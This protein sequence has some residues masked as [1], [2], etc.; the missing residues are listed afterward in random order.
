MKEVRGTLDNIDVPLS[1]L[2]I[3]IE[4]LLIALLAFMPLA[5]GARHA[6]SE[7]VVIILSCAITICFFLKLVLYPDQ[8]II[9][10]WAYIPILA[11]LL[12]AVL[13]LASLPV[14]LVKII[15]PNTAALKTEL[16]HDLSGAAGIKSMSLSFYRSA[17]KH[18]LRLVASIAA[19]FVVILNVF[20]KPSQIKRLLMA[21]SII[22]GIV[23][24]IAMAQNLFGNG[25][26]YW[27]VSTPSGQAS[28]GPFI[29]H[30]HFGQFMNLSIGAAIGLL[31]VKLHEVFG[32][33]KRGSFVFKY[34]FS[35]KAKFIWFLAAFI[36]I[37]AATLVI[38]LTRGGILSMLAAAVFTTL[39]INSRQALKARGWILA[40][41]ALG[42]FVCVLY[43]GFD[44][45]YD[46]FARLRNFGD[47]QCRLQILKDL[48]V[49]FKRFPILGMGLGT[50]AMVYPM[51]SHLS[52]SRI[53]THA[54]NEY[55]Q[56]ME[57]T[58]LLGLIIL[59]VFAVIIWSNYTKSVR[60][61]NTPTRPAVYGL[62]FGILAI[63]LHSITDYG[64]HI[65]ANAFLSAIFCALIIVLAQQG[66]NNK[67]YN[68]RIPI[69]NFIMLLGVSGICIWALVGANNARVAEAH[70]QRALDVE[71]SFIDKNWQGTEQEYA[72]LISHTAAASNAEQDNIK[73]RYWLNVY[74]WRS[75]SQEK[76]PETGNTVIHEEKIPVIYD[77][78]DQLHKACVLCPTYG[79]TYSV[80]GQLENFVLSN[81]AGAEQI[82]KG[83]RLAP[84]DPVACFVAGK[85][86][87]AEGKTDD[88]IEKFE[89]AVALDTRLF[90]KVV[91]IY[92]NQ[93]SR[94]HPAI[95]I[96]GN[97][98]GWL[99][100]VISLLE[101]MQ[102]YDLAQQTRTKV[103]NLLE[104]QC[105]QPKAIAST[106]A[107][108]ADIYR[109]QQN[110]EAAVEYYHSALA[111]DYGQVKWRFTLAKLLVEMERIPEAMREAERCLR[112][113]P[114]FKKARDLIADL[115]VHPMML[116]QEN[117]VP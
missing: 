8:N 89:K 105:R 73:Y 80:V 75:I 23:A 13:Q 90:V 29:N 97:N 17:T 59:I 50:H 67:V 54:E 25:K 94:P 62:G 27:F 93:I 14:S 91:D 11:F 88:C 57:E 10:T 107:S 69:V 95:E 26:I 22:G 84:C 87:I 66:R 79:P 52:T 61:I 109:L 78:V 36:V 28:S 60:N 63:L 115:S 46:R 45:V 102:Y 98:I 44:A 35:P 114:Q 47:Y 51:F 9:R 24:L 42:T 108:L 20:R 103:R 41:L 53:A 82:R 3:V 86:D 5:F 65:P 76:D 1:R 32:D 101:D 6:W 49:C 48:L 12:I 104:I 2:D 92:I 116:A 43:V 112:I 74:R 99:N 64:Q 110:N 7:E 83:F 19:V 15:S 37:G 39:I 18:D 16:L 30:S 81:P 96:A 85:L 40:V 77:I 72:E 33:K 34:L 31:M 55:A 70:W 117:P 71:K 58:G 68:C 100:H 4:W 113:R 21:I 38:S 111:R 106:F 56:T